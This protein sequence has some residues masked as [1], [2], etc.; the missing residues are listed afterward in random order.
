MRRYF[1]SA[2]AIALLMAIQ[3]LPAVSQ[4][5][6]LRYPKTVFNILD[7][8][9]YYTVKDTYK[10][11]IYIDEEIYNK[12]KR[13]SRYDRSWAIDCRRKQMA[14][15]NV[16]WQYRSGVWREARGGITYSISMLSRVFDFFC[17]SSN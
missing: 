5:R 7:H 12:G 2:L 14:S 17:T 6:W 15:D 9:V 4:G 10:G 8:E 13:L 3:C 1:T 11:I 16:V